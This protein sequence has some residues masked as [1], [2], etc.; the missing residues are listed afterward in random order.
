L[1]W[2]E[3]S[4]V[5]RVVPLA[6]VKVVVAVALLFSVALGVSFIFC[7][8]WDRLWQVPSL[9]MDPWK[10]SMKAL[11]RSSQESMEFGL[12]LSSQVKGADSKATEK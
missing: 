1:V 4:R 7:L 10:L 6:L 3:L 2:L 11:L 5:P 12:R 8:T 9:I